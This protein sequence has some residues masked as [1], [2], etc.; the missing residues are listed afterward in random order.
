MVECVAFGWGDK[1]ESLQLGSLFDVCYNIQ[2]N[3]FAGNENVQAVL[4]DARGSD[5][6]MAG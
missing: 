5:V 1:D 4:R 2:V 3:Q 6:S